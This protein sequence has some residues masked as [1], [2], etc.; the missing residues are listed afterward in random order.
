MSGKYKPTTVVVDG[1]VCLGNWC[2]RNYGGNYYGAIPLVGALTK[3]LNT[4]AVK[5]SIGIGDSKGGDFQRAK[6]GRAKIVDTAR[7]LGITTPLPD[8]VSLPIGAD[9]VTVIDHTSAYA[10]F[11]NGGKRVP[12]YAAVEIFNSHGESIYRHDRDNPPPQQVVPAK[13]VID[14]VSMM[15]KVV[16]EGT[17]KRAQ[18]GP[19]IQVAGKTGTTNGYKD[20]W[21]CGYTGNFTECV[22]FGN[23]DDTSMNNMTGGSLPAQTWH[24]IMVYAHNGVELKPLPGLPAP[25]PGPAVVNSGTVAELG[26]PQHPAQLSRRASDAIVS[27]EDLLRTADRQRAAASGADGIFAESASGPALGI[28]VRSTGGRIEVR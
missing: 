15:T 25:P 10:A 23:D 24:D 28:G 7:R 17:G 27:I 16:E 5:L 18:L 13:N 14:L 19:N 3:S 22:W 4:V 2:P 1:P 9:E 11:A 12:P 21:F 20:A 6:Q 8:T 26:V